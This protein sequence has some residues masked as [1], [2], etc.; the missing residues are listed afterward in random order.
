MGQKIKRH[1]AHRLLLLSLAL[2]I[3]NFN[4]RK[5]DISQSSDADKEAKFFQLP[6]NANISLQRVVDELKRQNKLT[7]FIG[8][9]ATNYGYPVWNKATIELR[10]KG[11]LAARGQDEGSNNDTTITIPLVLENTEYVD[12]AIV[13]HLTNNVAIF[14]YKGADYKEYPHGDNTATDMTAEQYAYQFIKMD[15]IVFNYAKYNII[16]D[17]LFRNETYPNDARAMV[18]SSSGTSN[19]SVGNCTFIVHWHNTEN[20]PVFDYT[21]NWVCSTLDDGPDLGDLHP[22]DLPIDSGGGGDNGGNNNTPPCNAGNIIANGKLPC[23]NG[24]IGVGW[25]AAPTD[26]NNEDPCAKASQVAKKMDSI[27][28]NSKADSVLA[29]ITNLATAT[30]EQGFPIIK[31]YSVNPFNVHDTIT[32]GYH[33]GSVH[34]GNDSSISY[35]VPLAYHEVQ[36]SALHTHPSSGYPAH[37]AMDVYILIDKY[38]QNN[39]YQGTFVAAANGNQFALT[40]TNLSQASAFFSTMAQNLNGT[41]W[42]KTSDIGKAFDKATEYFENQYKGNPNKADLAYEMAMA[43]LLTQYNVGITLN[44]KDASGNFKPLIVKTEPDSKNP[45]RTKYTQQCN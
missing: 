2:T 43:A 15:G 18:V 39:Q 23:D 36:V 13:A 20:G 44:K 45:K 29:T 28:I 11:T 34:Q 24:N 12:A 38:M 7:G 6:N 10:K 35:N 32:D 14:L 1:K 41:A 19:G 31:K 5:I 3:L 33:C 25:E 22:T 4:C 30:N 27:F 9:L 17:S 37:S 42:D 40:V 8:K 21:S 26:N 16:D